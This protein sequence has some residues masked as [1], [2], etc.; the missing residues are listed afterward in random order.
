MV[1]LR[2]ALLLLCPPLLSGCLFTYLVRSGYDQAQLLNNREPIEKVLKENKLTPE[3]RQKLE[4]T[5]KI[6]DFAT[7]KLHLKPTNSY[8]TFV[9]L[10]RPYVTYIVTVAKK[11]ELEPHL[12]WYPI[13]GSLPYKGFF[14]KEAAEEEAQ[15]FDQNKFDVMVRGVSAYSTLGWFED[16]LL[17]SMISGEDHHL[18]NLIIHEST[19]TTLYIKSQADFNEQLA[20]F[21]GNIGTEIYYKQKEG[22]NSST[23]KIIANEN[24]D[25]KIFSEF[26]SSELKS[27]AAWYKTLPE[28]NETARLQ[29]FSEIQTRFK[30]E[31][32][33]KMKTKQYAGFA[34]MKLNNATLL[35]FK[36]YVYDLNL[37]QK[38]Y[39]HF[40]KNLND[41]LAY[42]KSLE[43]SKNPHKDIEKLL[44]R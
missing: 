9:D 29:R 23:L 8:T 2:L 1:L 11:W 43:K 44:A 15:S 20:T 24:S 18:V 14:K 22:E 33:P 37:F 27:L 16:P 36:T 42:C 34:N 7:T 13:V 19:H 31:I 4:L 41:F 12:F 35:Y 21:V 30:T 26:I 10:K 32:A 5:V 39:E 28:K 25:E 17:S 6:R 3:Q 40:G 38:L